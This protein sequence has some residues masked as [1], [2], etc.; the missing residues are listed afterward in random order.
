MH[1]TLWEDPNGL[2]IRDENSPIGTYVNQNRIQGTVALRAGDQFSISSA[3]FM[4]DNAPAFQSPP[5][6]LPVAPEKKKAGGCWKWG[7]V[8]L[9][10]FL[11]LCLVLGAGG[12]YYL[13]TS[14]PEVKNLITDLNILPTPIPELDANGDQ[15]GPVDLDLKDPALNTSYSTSVRHVNSSALNGFGPK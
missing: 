14:N 3:V 8:G 10:L 5:P 1:A 2:F 13:Y 6:P 12:G 11:V 9:L 4:I 15:I 7:L